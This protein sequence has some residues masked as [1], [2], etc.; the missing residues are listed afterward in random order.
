MAISLKT[1][2]RGEPGV[3]GGGEKKF[4]ASPVTNGEVNIDE[5][6]ELIEMISTVSAIDV[7]GVLKSFITVVPRELS[8]GKIVRLGDLGY[9]RVS[10]SSEGYEN[11]EDVS[12]KSVK[13]TRILFTPGKELK[14]MLNNL[15]F[16]KANGTNS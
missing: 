14:K 6:S 12:G 10:I 2:E 11:A 1:I 4:Y 8:A 7:S 9:F 3:T 5:L 15:E 16:V 13:K